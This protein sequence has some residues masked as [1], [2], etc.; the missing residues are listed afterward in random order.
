MPPTEIEHVLDKIVAHA[1]P[2]LKRAYKID[3]KPSIVKGVIGLVL[4]CEIPLPRFNGQTKEELTTPVKEFGPHRWEPSKK[5][6]DAAA[7]RIVGWFAEQ[8][9][10]LS[11]KQD[12][13][14]TD[15][16]QK[17][18]DAL[19]F[20][21]IPKYSRATSKDRSLCS[22]FLCEGD[23]AAKPLGAAADKRVHGIYPLRGKIINAL[24]ASRKEFRANNEIK[25]LV[26][27]MGGLS[28]RGEVHE[29]KLRY[30]N[31][32]LAMDADVDGVHIR[33]LVLLAFMRYWPEFIKQGRL[34]FLVTPVVLA[35]RGGQCHEFFTESEYETAAE[36]VKFTRVKYLKGLG[37][38]RTE[39]FRRYLQD[40]TGRYMKTFVFDE[41]AEANMNLAF[42]DKCVAERK[43][44]FQDDIYYA[45]NNQ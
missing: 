29:E 38:N 19:K 15:Q 11:D 13:R 3:Y 6:L 44:L 27:I 43:T 2:R 22:L 17:E 31:V 45:N 37:S 4:S 41:Q 20:Y 10:I 8:H 40:T 16:T 9:Q 5:F 18:L 34:K 7:K 30:Q 25:S 36:S 33:G 23:S 21:Q 42:N 24:K 32:V 12:E 39:D 28:L 35:Y 26:S 14:E 1:R